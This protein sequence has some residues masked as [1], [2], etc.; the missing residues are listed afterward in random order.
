MSVALTF[1]VIF[2]SHEVVM[3]ASMN[4]QPI[5]FHMKRKHTGSVLVV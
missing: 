3:S 2:V 1:R 5:I 4:D